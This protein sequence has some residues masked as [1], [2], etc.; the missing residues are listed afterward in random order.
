MIAAQPKMPKMPETPRG[1]GEP[2]REEV[3]R[4]VEREGDRPV[5]FVAIGELNRSLLC[6]GSGASQH[7]P[8][9][10]RANDPRD[11]Y[12]SILVSAVRS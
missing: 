12:R 7:G 9:V 3:V 11:G 8:F 1:L 2:G 10:S 6:H 5:R 4:L